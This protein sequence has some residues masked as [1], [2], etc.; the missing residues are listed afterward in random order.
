V[1]RALTTWV[2]LTCG[3]EHYAASLNGGPLRCPRCRGSV[4]RPFDSPAPQDDVARDFLEST[5]RR[6][7]LGDADPDTRSTDIRDLGRM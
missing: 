3:S 2:C 5:A 1:E 7:V 4:F 6:L